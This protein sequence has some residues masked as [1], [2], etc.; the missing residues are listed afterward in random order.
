MFCSRFFMLYLI[1][2]N[3]QASFRAFNNGLKVDRLY[4]AE[5]VSH[6][7]VVRYSAISQLIVTFYKI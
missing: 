5:F 1:N 2:V 7:Q 3:L 4:A 6:I